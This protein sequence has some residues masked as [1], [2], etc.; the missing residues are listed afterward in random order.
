MKMRPCGQCRGHAAEASSQRSFPKVKL[1][2]TAFRLCPSCTVL[3]ALRHDPNGSQWDAR[4][5]G[6]VR[7]PDVRCE[8][9]HSTDLKILT[10]DIPLI[11]R[12][13]DFKAS[14]SPLF[15]WHLG[16]MPHFVNTAHQRVPW[17]TPSPHLF[18]VSSSP[19]SE[20][21]VPTCA[22]NLVRRRGPGRLLRAFCAAGWCP[23]SESR[24]V[25]GHISHPITWLDEW[26]NG[27]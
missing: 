25:C 7:N 4:S 12:F 13:S 21:S 6:Y 2:P 11:W 17:A 3:G 15:W 18:Q 16:D 10:T 9:F 27:G 20:T 14:F 22:W 1:P 8:L 24:L 19:R 5:D 26:M 23:N